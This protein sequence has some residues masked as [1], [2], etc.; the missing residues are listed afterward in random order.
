MCLVATLGSKSPKQLETWDPTSGYNVP[1]EIGR[2]QGWTAPAA[3][4]RGIASRCPLCPK[5]PP[6]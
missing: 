3:S 1:Q 5:Q 4:T 6:S 2:G